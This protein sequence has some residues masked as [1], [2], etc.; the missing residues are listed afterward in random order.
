[1]IGPGAPLVVTGAAGFLGRRVMEALGGRAI[2]VSRRPQPGTL[3][4]PLEDAAAFQNLLASRRPE[5]VLH[6][7][8]QVH[9]SEDE[10][11]HANVGLVEAVLA[12]AV[13]AG[14]RVV[15]VGSAAEYG[16]PGTS[17]PVPEDGPERPSSAYGR[18]KLAAT[19]L[20]E[21]AR[22]SGGDVTVGRLF[23]LVGPGMGTEHPFADFAAQVQRLPRSRGVV[24]VGNAD[25]V[26]DFVT[27]DFAVAALV[28]MATRG[29]PHGV[30]NVC[31]GR[32][33]R[34]G[35]AVQAMLDVRGI[36]AD[37][38][39]ADRPAIPAVVGDPRRLQATHGLVATADVVD[40]A[41]LALDGSSQI[42]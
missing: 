42:A 33:V 13:P 12:T 4:F 5:A 9:G 37:V 15:T 36:T 14:V 28:Q 16:D 3:N 40:L 10:L 41:R 18:T 38:V 1:M 39:S 23:N 2:G 30:V 8:G 22:A 6:L 24:H 11:Q 26:R 27:V 29:G 34:F 35:D 25:V 17:A 21:A 31:S 19:R 20:C 32:G 7:A